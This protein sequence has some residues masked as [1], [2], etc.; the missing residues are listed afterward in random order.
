MP[1]PRWPSGS[2]VAWLAVL[3]FSVGF[4]GLGFLGL[5]LYRVLYIY[6]GVNGFM[7]FSGLG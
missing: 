6:I 2:H 3:W 1:P 4:E 7:G 5:G